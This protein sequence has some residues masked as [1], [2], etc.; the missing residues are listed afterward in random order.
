M[1][2]RK[3]SNYVYCF[4]VNF[5]FISFIF[6]F[7]NNNGKQLKMLKKRPVENFYYFSM[8]KRKVSYYFI[9]FVFFSFCIIF[10]FSMTTEVN[11][12]NTE[13]ATYSLLFVSD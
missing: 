3:L 6:L 1:C 11:N 9:L 8:C 7:I 13:N 5:F 10:L 4:L 2:E 12:A